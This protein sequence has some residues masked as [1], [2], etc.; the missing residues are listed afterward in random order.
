M[1]VKRMTAAA[2]P[3]QDEAYPRSAPDRPA[4]DDEDQDLSD[5]SRGPEIADDLVGEADGAPIDAGEGIERA[6]AA[7]GQRAGDE[8][9]PQDLGEAHRGLVR[10]RLVLN[11]GL[12]LLVRHDDQGRGDA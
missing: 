2:D 5:D 12:R 11:H 9:Q 1:I 3:N 6:V 4:K 10:L 7:L 8:D